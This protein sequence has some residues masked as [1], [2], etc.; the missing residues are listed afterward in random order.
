MKNLEV[1]YRLKKVGDQV[2]YVYMKYGNYDP[3]VKLNIYNFS[4]YYVRSI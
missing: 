2:Q 4:Y 3:N 1:Y